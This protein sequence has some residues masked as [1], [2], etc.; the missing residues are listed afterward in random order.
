[1]HYR[2]ASKLKKVTNELI[3][4]NGV[5]AKQNRLWTY[6]HNAEHVRYP[7]TAANPLVN[8]GMNFQIIRLMVRE[9]KK[10]T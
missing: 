2:A 5:H 3:R 10:Y 8:F 9:S 4:L 6:M 1:M 7:Y